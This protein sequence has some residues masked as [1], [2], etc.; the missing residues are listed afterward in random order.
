LETDVVQTMSQLLL[1][2][3]VKRKMQQLVLGQSVGWSIRMM[4]SE[5]IFQNE[6]W[7]EIMLRLTQKIS[8]HQRPNLSERFVGMVE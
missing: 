2:G 3:L 7:Q 8:K 1:N 4:H 5:F 6:Q